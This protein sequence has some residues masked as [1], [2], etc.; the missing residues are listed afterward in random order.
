[1]KA[2]APHPQVPSP[3]YRQLGACGLSCVYIGVGGLAR[4]HRGCCTNQIPRRNWFY[5]S[6]G[7]GEWP[8]GHLNREVRPGKH[9]SWFRLFCNSI[10]VKLSM[11][12]GGKV[13]HSLCSIFL[14]Q[15]VYL[16]SPFLSLIFRGC[17]AQ[18]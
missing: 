14:E 18:G 12:W 13:E 15:T 3:Q 11:R 9:R 6:T 17:N 5:R 2:G 4:A 8:L 7:S 10:R 16:S 1:M